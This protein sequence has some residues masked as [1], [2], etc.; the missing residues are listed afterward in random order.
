[1][2]KARRQSLVAVD[3]R[4]VGNARFHRTAQWTRNYAMCIR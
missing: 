4:F 2:L 1:M 3:V